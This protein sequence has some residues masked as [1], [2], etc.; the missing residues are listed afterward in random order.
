MPHLTGS[1]AL[2]AATA[3]AL[4]GLSG[5]TSDRD[6]S[7]TGAGATTAQ[8]L[9]DLDTTD[10]PADIADE[11]VSKVSCSYLTVPEDRSDPART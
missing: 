5:C 3:L 6:P 7:P 8:D 11:V 9:V 4:S 2:V 10:C 1:V